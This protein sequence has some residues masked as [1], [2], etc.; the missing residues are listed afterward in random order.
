MTKNKRVIRAKRNTI[1]FP[2]YQKCWT[3]ASFPLINY[4][5]LTTNTTT[6]KILQ[7]WCSLL[8]D[9]EACA[10]QPTRA[11]L[12]TPP[13]GRR[14]QKQPWTTPV[15]AAPRFSE[16]SPLGRKVER[17]WH[18]RG[19]FRE[20]ELLRGCLCGLQCV[21][22][23]SF[24]E[25]KTVRTAAQDTGQNSMQVPQVFMQV[26]RLTGFVIKR[27]PIRMWPEFHHFHQTIQN[28][29]GNRNKLEFPLPCFQTVIK[30]LL[31]RLSVISI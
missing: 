21:G 6:M 5:S 9:E 1:K 30:P 15:P 2:H 27:C 7:L 31:N 24:L 23:L 19:W 28:E 25:N 26:T 22:S 12:S 20:K 16:A 11:V 14:P 10:V 8:K 18:P 4:W 29:R 3:N 17:G 13:G